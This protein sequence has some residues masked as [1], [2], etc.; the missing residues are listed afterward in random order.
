MILRG[1]L[2]I[3]SWRCSMTGRKLIIDT[4]IGTDLDDALALIY[5][6]RSGYQVPLITTVH[7]D[8]MQRARIAKKLTQLLG[9][10]I[11]VVAGEDKP[12]KQQQLYWGGYEGFGFLDGTEKF[13]IP[14]GGVEALAQAVYEHAN[15]IDIACIGPLTN[16]ARAFQ[17]YPDLS[18]KVSNLLIMGRVDL[19][20]HPE[21]NRTYINY[22]PHN[23]KVD[24]EAVDIIFESATPKTIISTDISKKNWLTRDQL[25]AL[26]GGDMI[27]NYIGTSGLVWLDRI[28]SECTY[29]YDPLTIAHHGSPDLT[30]R[31]CHN[32]IAI[33]TD[34]CSPGFADHVYALLRNNKG[35]KCRQEEK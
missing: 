34:M 18:S 30:S 6:V 3:P 25:Q 5:A 33:A 2:G 15:A 1:L 7:G 20:T 19:F 12:I 21:G 24:P 32:E 31:V 14:S 23:F 28:K 9:V 4:D 27:E 35:Y 16:I 11:P 17:R 22:R 26:Q 10:E 8:A 29:L 13:D